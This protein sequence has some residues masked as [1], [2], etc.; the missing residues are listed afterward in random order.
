MMYKTCNA[1]WNAQDKETEPWKKG[2]K[3]PTILPFSCGPPSQSPLELRM[4][5][6]RWHE[7]AWNPLK[8]LCDTMG[9]FILWWK[10]SDWAR[11]GVAC[12]I[13]FWLFQDVCELCFNFLV[14][15][16]FC[17]G[18]GLSAA[19][20]TFCIISCY[21][22]SLKTL[23]LKICKNHGRQVMHFEW[24]RQSSDSSLVQ[25]TG[26]NAAVWTQPALSWSRDW[27]GLWYEHTGIQPT[28]VTDTCTCQHRAANPS[29]DLSVKK[30]NFK[31][32]NWILSA[33]HMFW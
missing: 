21:S 31:C 14:F 18:V 22:E 29:L 30:S 2:M 25:I 11:V 27:P 13:Y 8:S 19:H 20:I 24:W 32:N 33:M 7:I 16:L 28:H 6:D 17:S 12:C 5:R 23:E 10:F 15:F 9:S 1:P 26:A 3:K 4:T